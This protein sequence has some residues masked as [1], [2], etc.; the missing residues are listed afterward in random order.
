MRWRRSD[1][2]KEGQTLKVERWKGIRLFMEGGV[3]I[4]K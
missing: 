4:S 2:G 3:I 1:G